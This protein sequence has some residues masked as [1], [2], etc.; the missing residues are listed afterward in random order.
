[1][2]QREETW[3]R[4]GHLS[5]IF[6]LSHSLLKT[7][8]FWEHF[9]PFYFHKLM[10]KVKI[11]DLQRER[12]LAGHP[13]I[14]G[15]SKV[16]TLD[17]ELGRSTMVDR[18]H[19]TWRGDHKRQPQ[20]GRSKIPE[21]KWGPFWPM[22]NQVNAW[23]DFK[24]FDAGTPSE[25]LDW[26]QELLMLETFHQGNDRLFVTNQKFFNVSSANHTQQAQS[27]DVGE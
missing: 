22:P 2:E 19:A 6:V 7:R 21:A 10:G 13:I 14:E 8:G 26:S 1:M 23:T 20:Q 25:Y 27:L 4:G 15:P 24:N 9:P 11:Q 17:S 16:G 3:H 12:V 5:I 18:G